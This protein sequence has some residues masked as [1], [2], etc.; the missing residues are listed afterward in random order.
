V[1]IHAHQ[2]CTAKEFCANSAE[3]TDTIDYAKD[4]RRSQQQR[5]ATHNV[6][7][8][9]AQHVCKSFPNHRRRKL[10]LRH[11]PRDFALKTAVFE[12]FDPR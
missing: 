9:L 7:S 6:S 3:N 5:T 2:Q 8:N 10:S 11:R 4:Y 1:Q 12:I